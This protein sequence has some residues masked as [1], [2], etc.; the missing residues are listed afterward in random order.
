MF[1]AIDKFKFFCDLVCFPC[2]S[3]PLL[4]NL[5]NLDLENH[6]SDPQS[7]YIHLYFLIHFNTLTF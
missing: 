5:E 1:Y 4:L 3:P 7:K 2:A 6:H